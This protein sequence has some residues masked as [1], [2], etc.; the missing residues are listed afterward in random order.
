[1]INLRAFA[2][3]IAV[4]C[5]VP[6]I[7]QVAAAQVVVPAGA[8]RGQGT[9]RNALTFQSY[10]PGHT[11]AFYA[12]KDVGAK[13]TF[14]SLAF[15]HYYATVSPAMTLDLA[16]MLDNSTVA[17]NKQTTVFAN[18]LK[19]PTAVFT[20]KL[21][22]PARAKVSTW[23]E[24]WEAAISFKTLFAWTAPAGGSLVVDIVTKTS[25]TATQFWYLE[26]VRRD[27]FGAAGSRRQLRPHCA[28]NTGRCPVHPTYGSSL[29]G[30][31]WFVDYKYVPDSVPPKGNSMLVLGAR[32]T[33]K[34]FGL[35]LPVPL[36]KLGLLSFGCDLGVSVDV[37]LPMAFTTG[38]GTTYC[39]GMLSSPRVT[40]PNTIPG[41]TKFYSQ[42][43]VDDPIQWLSLVYSTE[44]VEWT[45]GN[46]TPGPQIEASY[47]A[48]WTGVFKPMQFPNKGGSSVGWPCAMATRTRM[49]T[50]C[51]STS[52][53]SS[54]ATASSSIPAGRRPRARPT[55]CGCC[56]WRR[57][58]LSAR[59]WRP[60]PGCGMAS[61][62]G[63]PRGS[64]RPRSGAAAPSGLGSGRWRLPSSS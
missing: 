34:Q 50:S 32:A 35:D 49:P 44:V 1:M 6:A 15:R 24:P 42:V 26:E 58:S 9:Q 12:T 40:I 30:K 61:A 43:L 48:E 41:G 3:A 22:L 62:P 53:T 18:N 8:T 60:P 54:L 39:K 10:A 36:A 33:G 4:F 21:N 63:S 55:S 14:K 47:L 19:N 64:S 28:R 56:S 17:H 31:Q 7:A 25:V 5:T 23:P 27:T 37:L 29:A 38:A 16:L 46:Q 45:V 13:A 57:W 59:T 2:G 11:Q 52:T 51:S 20:G